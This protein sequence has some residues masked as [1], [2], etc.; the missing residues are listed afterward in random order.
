M[1]GIRNNG[2]DISDLDT[3]DWA[4]YKGINFGTQGARGLVAKLGVT[5]Q[6]AGGII[7]VYIDSTANT[8]VARLT[9]VST[10]TWGNYTS[11]AAVTPLIT[12]THDVYIS[13]TGTEVAALDGFGFTRTIPTR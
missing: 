12:G 6:F 3:N 1:Q 2:T 7:E 9:A 8:P 10:N 11:Q 4:M 13:F 5:P